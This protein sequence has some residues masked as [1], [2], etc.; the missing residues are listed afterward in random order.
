MRNRIA[1][2]LVL[3]AVFALVA[4]CRD[5]NKQEQCGVEIIMIWSAA[6]GNDDGTI[7]HSETIAAGL[8]TMSKLAKAFPDKV[9][10]EGSLKTDDGR[11]AFIEKV[12]TLYE[13]A[14]TESAPTP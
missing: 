7:S 4:G 5:L 8:K 13:E 14:T 11:E 3:L 9:K 2:V 6:D 1:I 12:I 10:F